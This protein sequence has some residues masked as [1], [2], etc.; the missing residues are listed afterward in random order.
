MENPTTF[1]RAKILMAEIRNFWK[2]ITIDEIEALK[3]AS[4]DEKN[5]YFDL[6]SL[7]SSALGTFSVQE[8]SEINLKLEK[9]RTITYNN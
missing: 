5:I 6:A 8:N 1:D 2:S 9:V 7:A 4:R 3:D